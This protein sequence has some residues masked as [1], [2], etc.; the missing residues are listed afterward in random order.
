MVTYLSDRP[1]LR[2]AL[3]RGP[4]LGTFASVGHA[5]S[6]EIL[7][8]QG[9]DAVCVDAEHAALGPAEIESLIVRFV[10][11]PDAIAATSL[12][13]RA[14]TWTL[15]VTITTPASSRR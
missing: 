9:F 1:S 13:Y 12:Q 11:T 4:V 14:T 6:V 15:C 5:T 2:D 8:S 3:L 10:G 7:A